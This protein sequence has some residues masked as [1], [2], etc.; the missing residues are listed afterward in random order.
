MVD[1]ANFKILSEYAFWIEQNCRVSL[2]NLC[3]AHFFDWQYCFSSNSEFKS[4]CDKSHSNIQTSGQGIFYLAF[5]CIF[6][7]TFEANLA[8]AQKWKVK[9][10]SC[11]IFKPE[12]K[13][14]EKSNSNEQVKFDP[15][16]CFNASAS[17]KLVTFSNAIK[18][19]SQR[20][21]QMCPTIKCC[22]I[23]QLAISS[24]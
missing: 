20:K 23:N 15:V 16:A 17:L 4:A 19:L 7:N 3:I 22:Q 21:D 10:E 11:P 1:S 14:D 2:N 24:S 5:I 12:V 13:F 9:H 8:K 6:C 18:R